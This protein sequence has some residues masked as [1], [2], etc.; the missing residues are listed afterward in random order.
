MTFYLIT[1]FLL[2]E[3]GRSNSTALTVGLVVGFALV[4]LIGVIITIVI[5]LLKRRKNR[6]LLRYD[7]E[8]QDCK[9]NRTGTQTTF[10]AIYKHKAGPYI[11]MY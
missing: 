9:Q 11:R 5:T 2:T 7:V 1:F 6:W 3:T 4:I 8:P 10:W